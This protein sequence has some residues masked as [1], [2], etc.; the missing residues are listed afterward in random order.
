MTEIIAVITGL[1]FGGGIAWLFLKAKIQAA[2]DKARADAVGERAALVATFQA[3]EEKV[4]ELTSALEIAKADYV[5]VQH[6]FLGASS[7]LAVAEE[8]SGRIPVLET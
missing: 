3:R 5:R 4:Q 8:K 2:G 6:E 1:V 7:K